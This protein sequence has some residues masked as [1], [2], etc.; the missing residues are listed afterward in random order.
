MVHYLG[1][2]IKINNTTASVVQTDT[3][4]TLASVFTCISPACAKG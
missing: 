2:M 1:C 3:H 4:N